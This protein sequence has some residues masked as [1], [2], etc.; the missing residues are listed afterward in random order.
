MALDPGGPQRP[1]IPKCGWGNAGPARLPGKWLTHV[2]HGECRLGGGGMMAAARTPGKGSAPSWIGVCRGRD[3]DATRERIKAH[4]RCTVPVPRTTFQQVGRFSVVADP[5]SAVC[6]VQL[7]TTATR[8]SQSRRPGP[9]RC[10]SCRPPTGRRRSRSIARFRL[11]G[12]PT[13]GMGAMASTR[14]S[15]GGEA[16]AA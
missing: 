2:H 9:C 3:V 10:T 8:R 12:R 15:V 14:L 6:A 5:Q 16:V 11:A 4:R 7:R 1:Y 13:Y